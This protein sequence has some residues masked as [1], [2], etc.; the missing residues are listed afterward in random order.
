MR[1]GYHTTA[2]TCLLRRVSF[3]AILLSQ[4]LGITFKIYLVWLPWR[5]GVQRKWFRAQVPK[6]ANHQRAATHPACWPMDWDKLGRPQATH[7]AVFSPSPLFS[8][9]PS[10][11]VHSCVILWIFPSPAE[12]H[13]PTRL[14]HSSSPFTSSGLQRLIFFRFDA[15]PGSPIFFCVTPRVLPK[16]PTPFEEIQGLV[17]PC[18]YWLLGLSYICILNVIVLV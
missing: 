18:S 9:R 14:F 11:E 2:K 13:R 7:R 12:P 16:Q 17:S 4:N 1:T 8:P 3:K 15:R 5:L 6:L 10:G